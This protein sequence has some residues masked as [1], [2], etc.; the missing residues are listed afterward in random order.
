MYH[1]IDA[2]MVLW[3]NPELHCFHGSLKGNYD[4]FEFLNIDV[5]L[6]RIPFNFFQNSVNPD[7]FA[8]GIKYCHFCI[9]RTPFGIYGFP[10]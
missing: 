1:Q 7:D 8:L 4:C 10:W 2:L 5:T 6:L 3:L 9:G